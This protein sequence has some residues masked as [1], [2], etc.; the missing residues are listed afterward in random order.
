MYATS[1]MQKKRKIL[2]KEKKRKIFEIAGQ[3]QD[4]ALSFFNS[5]PLYS[6]KYNTI[7]MEQFI[8]QNVCG[9]TTFRKTTFRKTTFSKTTFSIPCTLFRLI[10]FCRVYR[11]M[12]CDIMLSVVMLNATCPYN[13]NQAVAYLLEPS[14]Y[15][16]LVQ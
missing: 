13:N 1:V 9:T 5:I 8:C 15:Q 6:G 11:V 2:L 3:C 10:P 16:V 12:M 14:A 4:S 7:L